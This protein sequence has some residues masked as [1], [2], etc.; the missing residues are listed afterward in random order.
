[1]LKY[2][3][4][5]TIAIF[6]ALSLSACESTSMG[7]ISLNNEPA[8][9][10]IKENVPNGM[11]VQGMD[12]TINSD[13]IGTA[14]RIGTNRK[15]G[16]NSVTS[17]EPLQSKYGEITISQNINGSMGGLAVSFDVFIDGNF[18]GNVQMSNVM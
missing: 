16:M 10:E 17:F 14:R 15:A 18:A 8:K 6:V 7:A 5:Y 9:I 4:K 1:M 2:V 12:I 3:S 13:F 11:I